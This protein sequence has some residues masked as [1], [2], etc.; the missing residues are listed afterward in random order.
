MELT[1]LELTN[2]EAKFMNI[3]ERLEKIEQK[4]PTEV[5]VDSEMVAK[6]LNPNDLTEMAARLN[7]M[8]NQMQGNSSSETNILKIENNELREECKFLHKMLVDERR[9][10]LETLKYDTIENYRALVHSN[11]E[12]EKELQ[13]ATRE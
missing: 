9:F 7:S 13:K 6:S 2:I 8:S 5:T 1:T 11:R 12:H 3:F 4:E 10:I